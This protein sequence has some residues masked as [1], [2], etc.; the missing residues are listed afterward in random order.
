MQ[1]NTIERLKRIDKALGLGLSVGICGAGATYF[2]DAADQ[3]AGI[4]TTGG[5]QPTSMG[6]GYRNRV[7]QR[8]M[9]HEIHLGHESSPYHFWLGGGV[10]L[11][12][13]ANHSEGNYDVEG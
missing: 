11:A 13:L 2:L 9:L 5:H 8:V 7:G 10:S 1:L 3:K 4:N 12:R 6:V